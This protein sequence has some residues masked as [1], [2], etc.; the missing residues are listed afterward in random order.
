[1]ATYDNQ[2]ANP[3]PEA[4]PAPQGERGG[5]NCGGRCGS[6]GGPCGK[7]GHRRGRFLFVLLAVLTVAGIGGFI[8]RSFAFGPAH[9]G[10]RDPA[11]HAERMVK[12]IASEVKAT[13]EQQAR[14]KTI[15]E[16]VAKD[17]SPLHDRIASSRGDAVKLLSAPNVDRAAIEALRAKQL[18]AAD[19]ASKRVS[20][21]LADMAE[22]LTPEQR[23]QLAQ[24][25]EKHFA[26]F[27]RW[28]R[29]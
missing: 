22:V 9:F 18:A 13:P 14:L 26:R 27:E 10:A 24:K 11:A 21:A 1:M 8:G 20:L 16:G 7:R 19:E 6:A 3:Q 23:Q 2:P 12:R 15:A 25:A 17:L 5:R 29:G 28:H 4:E